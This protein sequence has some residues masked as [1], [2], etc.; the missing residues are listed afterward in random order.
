MNRHP[1]LKAYMAGVLVPT[2]FLL[3]ILAG[4]VTVHYVWRWPIPIERAVVFPMAIVPNL[5]GAWNVV[6]VAFGLRRFLPLGAFGAL[7]PFLLMPSGLWLARVLEIPFVTASAGLIVL[8][9][10]LVVYYLLWK[11]AVAFFNDVVG[12]G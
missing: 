9:V 7:M 10:G 1:Y 3:V 2:W 8:P 12:V 5:W 6:Y 4:F 11:H